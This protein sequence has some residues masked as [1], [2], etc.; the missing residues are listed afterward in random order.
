MVTKYQQ[1]KKSRHRKS[2]HSSLPRAKINALSESAR[3]AI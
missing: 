2:D 1:K 3:V